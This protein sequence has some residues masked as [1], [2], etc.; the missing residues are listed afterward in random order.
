VVNSVFEV[1]QAGVWTF[2]YQAFIGQPQPT[3]VAAVNPPP[4]PMPTI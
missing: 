4:A 1:W 3:A 2:A